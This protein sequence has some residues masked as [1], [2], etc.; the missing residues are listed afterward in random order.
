MKLG[1][2]KAGGRGEGTSVRDAELRH[3]CT[4]GLGVG[5]GLGLPPG[6][7]EINRNPKNAK[8]IPNLKFLLVEPGAVG[9][10]ASG[11]RHRS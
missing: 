2:T 10:G 1:P 3:G 9:T 8:K 5:D 4:V 11:K 6:S 7:T